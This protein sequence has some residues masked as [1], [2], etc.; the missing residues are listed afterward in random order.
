MDSKIIYLARQ[1]KACGLKSGVNASPQS[2]WEDIA[3]YDEFRGAM[4]LIHGSFIQW[5]E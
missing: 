5:S 3:P 1:Q 4:G 2:Y